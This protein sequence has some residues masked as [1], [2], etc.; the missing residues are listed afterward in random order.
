M[1]AVPQQR[2]FS[3]QIAGRWQIPLLLISVALLTWGVWRLRPEPQV[4]TFDE[5]FNH[6][7]RLR[8]AGLSAVVEDVTPARVAAGYHDLRVVRQRAID[9][10]T[11]QLAVAAFMS[12]PCGG[13]VE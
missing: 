8:E 13:R 6:A 9:E 7:A 10:Q 11:V 12:E 4:P 1:S 2:V 3:E 5:L